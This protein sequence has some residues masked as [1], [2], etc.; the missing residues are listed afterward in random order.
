MSGWSLGPD[1]RHLRISS[2]T[3]SA[4]I[5][6]HIFNIE[7]QKEI[8]STRNRPVP[9]G[10]E[11][12]CPAIQLKDGR[13]WYAAS[14]IVYQRYVAEVEQ[15]GT[16]ASS[17]P[18]EQWIVIKGSNT[19]RLLQPNASIRQS[20]EIPVLREKHSCIYPNTLEWRSDS[21]QLALRDREQS[22]TFVWTIG[23]GSEVIQMET[24]KGSCMST[25]RYFQK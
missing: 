3:P 6:S 11:S 24:V 20:I 19:L 4:G 15:A 18:D 1:G 12:N 22:L 21:K 23:E 5:G 7:A 8:C 25:Q 10:L 17:S 13:W 2:G 16:Y 14:D 9:Q